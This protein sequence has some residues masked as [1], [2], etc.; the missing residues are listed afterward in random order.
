MS[1]LPYHEKLHLQ[2]FTV[3]QDAE[4]SFVPGI[5]VLVGANGTGKT[6][7]MKVLFGYQLA[8]NRGNARHFFMLQDVFQMNELEEIIRLPSQGRKTTTE[9][10]WN[11]T[12]W[13]LS[14]DSSIP[15]PLNAPLSPGLP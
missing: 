15:N 10:R 14:M 3:F 9:G 1:T 12:A 5:N 8:S 6:H 2:N 11:G 4:F 13:F 7:L